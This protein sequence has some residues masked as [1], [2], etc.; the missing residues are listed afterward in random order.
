MHTDTVFIE[1][2]STYQKI[3]RIIN[4]FILFNFNQQIHKVTI[5]LEGRGK[6][7]SFLKSMLLQNFLGELREIFSLN[8]QFAFKNK[9]NLILNKSEYNLNF[10]INIQAISNFNSSVDDI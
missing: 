10:V 1:G 9:I 3:G 5:K 8:D 2:A 7:K 4:I 6:D